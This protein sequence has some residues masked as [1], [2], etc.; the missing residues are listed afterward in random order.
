V[1]NAASNIV[2]GLPNSTIAQG[3]VFLLFRSGLGPSSIFIAPIFS[4]HQLG[5]DVGSCQRGR[6]NGECAPVLLIRRSGCRAPAL[7]YARRI[8]SRHGLLQRG[9]QRTRTYN[10]GRQ[11]PSIFTVGSNG[12]GPAIVTYPDY[13]LVSAVSATQ[14]ANCGGANITCGAANP[15]DTLILWATGA[16]P[17]TGNESAGSGLGV[18]MPNIPLTVRLGGVQAPISYPGP[19]GLLHRRRSDSVYAAEQ[20]SHR[21]R[22]AAGGADQ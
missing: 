4:E 20:R 2:S 15:G 16:G 6:H 8:G 12:Q 5:R 17:V 7:E 13:S 19:L 14:A 18:N 11:N 21:M 10:S 22:R 1:T 9:G 3:S